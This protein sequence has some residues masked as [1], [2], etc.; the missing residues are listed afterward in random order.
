MTDCDLLCSTGEWSNDTRHG[1]GVLRLFNGL[2]FDGTFKANKP[3]GRGVCVYPDKSRYEGVWRNGH[4]NGRGT[5]V[6]TNGATYEGRFKDDLIHG[7]GTLKMKDGVP[8]N[9]P[10]DQW[11]V[12]VDCQHELRFVHLKSGFNVDGL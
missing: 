8:V 9:V 12:P 6:F 1:K 11:I 2:V 3:D 7:T 4:K 10:P 5:Y